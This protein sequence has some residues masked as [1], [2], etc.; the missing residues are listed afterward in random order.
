MAAGEVCPGF[1]PNAK[2]W[3]KEFCFAKLFKRS[4]G[5]GGVAGGWPTTLNILFRASGPPSSAGGGI[6]AAF[7]SH[8]V[9]ADYGKPGQRG[10][11]V[12][13]AR[14]GGSGRDG[15][16]TGAGPRR[17]GSVRPNGGRCGRA[18]AD[19]STGVRVWSVG[20]TS[21]SCLQLGPAPQHRGLKP[22]SRPR[23]N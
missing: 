12:R 23:H 14:R 3:A 21:P 16:V 7:S 19:V 1:R 4:G 13:L 22:E 20:E 5:M 10:A 18:C 11:L 9:G 15:G 8:L 2:H 6:R 17:G